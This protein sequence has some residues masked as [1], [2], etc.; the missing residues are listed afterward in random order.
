LSTPRVAVDRAEVGRRGGEVDSMFRW[1]EQHDGGHIWCGLLA[2]GAGRLVL[3]SGGRFPLLV[4]WRR[5]SRT[6]CWLPACGVWFQCWVGICPPPP[7]SVFRRQVR[8]GAWIWS[9]LLACGSQISGASSLAPPS[10]YSSPG[11]WVSDVAW[12]R[13]HPCQASAA[14]LR[15]VG[16][17]GR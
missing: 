1:R 17:K 4:F 3:V 6:S 15:H 7:P 11:R 13:R 2:P 14:D 9:W 16:R 10:P 8:R 12:R 5:G